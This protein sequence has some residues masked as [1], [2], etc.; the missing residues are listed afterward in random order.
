MPHRELRDFHEKM[1]KRDKKRNKFF[2]NMWKGVKGFWKILKPRD[3]L[4]SSRVDIDAEAPV[5][6]SGH[7]DTDDDAKS[8]GEINYRCGLKEHPYLSICLIVYKLRTLLAF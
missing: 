5:E 4:P 1:V 6:L 7:E 8:E 2:T 3:R